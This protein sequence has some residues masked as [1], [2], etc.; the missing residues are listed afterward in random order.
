MLGCPLGFGGQHLRV[1]EA[2]GMEMMDKRLAAIVYPATKGILADWLLVEVATRLQ[3]LRLQLAGAVQL[4]THRDN[5]RRCDMFM[6]DLSSG[7]LVEISEYRGPQAR[8]C[9]LDHRALEDMVGLSKAAVD[10]GVDLLIV[11]RFGKR[12]AKGQGFRQTMDAAITKGI[13]V[14]TTVGTDN[15]THWRHYTADFAEELPVDL[16][17]AMAWCLRTARTAE[18]V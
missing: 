4:N 15:L 6:R 18:N 3:G 2:R 12:E 5:R 11:N 17:S 10:R 16:S 13:P 14:L 9:R 8:G 7:E 1:G